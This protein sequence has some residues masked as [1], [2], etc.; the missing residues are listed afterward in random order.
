[1]RIDLQQQHLDD[2]L[3]NIKKDI[4]NYDLEGYTDLH[5]DSL[6]ESQLVTRQITFSRGNKT[7]YVV[8]NPVGQIRA[9]SVD[10][11]PDLIQQISNTSISMMYDQMVPT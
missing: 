7:H 4:Y 11:P 10:T 8:L 9:M 1:M 5:L 6:N 3:M 2:L